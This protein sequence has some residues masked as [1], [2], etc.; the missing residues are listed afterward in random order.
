MVSSLVVILVQ[1][2][3]QAN[4]MLAFF[5]DKL[6]GDDCKIGISDKTRHTDSSDN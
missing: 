3:M 4:R 2:L 6:L 1:F 5:F